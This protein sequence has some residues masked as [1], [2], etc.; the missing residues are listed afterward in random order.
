MVKVLG[1]WLLTAVPVVLIVSMLTFVLTSLVPGDAARAILGLQASDAQVAALRDQLGLDKPLPRQYWDWLVGVF[2]GDLGR[3]IQ[4]RGLV[5]SELAHRAEVTM[6]LLLLG[7]LI[8]AVVGI[9][10]GVVSAV[11]GGRIGKLVDVLSL[12]G[13]AVPGFW[14]GLV[15]VTVFAVAIPL[16]PATGYVSFTHSVPGWI[17]SLALPLLT[18]AL[19]GTATLAKQTRS[20]VLDELGKDYVRMLRARGIPERR[21]LM[22]HVLRNAAGPVVTIVGLT[23]IGLVSGAVLLETV[24]VLPGIGMLMVQ[25]SKAHDI[26]VIQGVTLLVS[27]VVVVVNLLVEISYALLDPRVRA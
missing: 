11:R 21:I 22:V 13:I 17:A 19:T 16:F 2:H 25:A 1:R 3:S 15:L 4:T 6:S 24:F 23:F 9:A 27:L 5:A 12:V 18:L 20:S 14:L 8:V 26:P 7:V 10:L